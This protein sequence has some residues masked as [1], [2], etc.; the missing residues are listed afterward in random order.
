MSKCPLFTPHDLEWT[1]EKIARFWDYE[2]RNEAKRGKYFTLLM[3]DALVRLAR[4]KGVLVEPVLD[5][6]AGVGGLTERLARQGLRCMA[7]DYSPASVDALNA[8]LKDASSFEGCRLIEAIPTSLPADSF[9]LVYLVETL[10][11][12][13]QD[14]MSLTLG[15]VRRLLRPGGH[16]LVTVPHDENLEM[17]KVICADCGAVFHRVQHVNSYNETSLSAVM[18]KAG[19]A[20][21]FCQPLQLW[22]WSDEGTRYAKTLRARLRRIL[23]RF[24]NRP[25]VRTTPHLVY[26]GRKI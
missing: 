25:P 16:V 5:Y 24:R 9:G 22:T 14:W 15:E 21:V 10:E 7:C 13:Q 23:Q 20:C 12:L 6:G 18:E 26:I 1:P 11:H 2:S 17:G 3:G 8:R 19:F 4:R